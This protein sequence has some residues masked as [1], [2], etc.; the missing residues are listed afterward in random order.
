MEPCYSSRNMRIKVVSVCLGAVLSAFGQSTNPEL[1]RNPAE[2]LA[3]A[4]PLYDFG[5]SSLK[6][7]HLKAAYQLYDDKGE[8]AGQG[9]YEHWWVSPELNRSTWTRSGA[10]EAI[11][12]R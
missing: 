5:S 3:M 11:S 7:W 2:I 9:S 12:R 10:L 1:P 6:P 4:A 8:P